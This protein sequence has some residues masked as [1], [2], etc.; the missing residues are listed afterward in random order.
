MIAVAIFSADTAL[1]RSLEKLLGDEQSIVS[2]GA[3]D[4]TAA[5]PELA[6]KHGIDVILVHAPL[7]VQFADWRVAG[8]ETPG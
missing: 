8:N 4:D 2:L 6:E 7:I 1:R 3:V 5:L